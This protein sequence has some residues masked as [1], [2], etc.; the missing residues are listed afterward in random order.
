MSCMMKKENNNTGTHKVSDNFEINKL[1]TT[2]GL[3]GDPVAIFTIPLIEARYG[4]EHILSEIRLMHG[5]SKHPLSYLS[6][7]M[8]PNLV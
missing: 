4:R 6:M 8:E 1:Y 2:F 7:S 5:L 3:S